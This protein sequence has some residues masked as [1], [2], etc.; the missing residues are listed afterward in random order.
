[1]KARLMFILLQT[2]QNIVNSTIMILTAVIVG[3]DLPALNGP[4]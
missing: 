2:N 3:K 1:M 4:G